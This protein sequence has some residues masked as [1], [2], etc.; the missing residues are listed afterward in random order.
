[1]KSDD[2]L[3]IS[4]GGAA[5]GIAREAARN[6][7]ESTG[8]PVRALILDTDDETLLSCPPSSGVS[9]SIFG[10]KRLSGSGTG[11]DHRLGAGALR[12]D[13]SMIQQQIGTPH[14]AI[15]L[16][17][18]GGGTSGAGSHLLTQ[19]RDQGVAT[20]TIATVPFSFEGDDRKRCAAV[21]LPT[22][23]SASDAI[24][25][26]PLDQLIPESYRD[27][28]ATEAFAYAAD[29]LAAGIGLFWTLL[30]RP[31]FLAFDATRF[32]QFITFGGS[33]GL[34]FYF[35]DATASGPDRARIILDQLLASPLFRADGIDR[36]AN[37]AN[38]VVGVL[39]GEDLRLCEL[40]T[41]MDGLRGYC[42]SLKE[43]F[44]G[45]ALAPNPDGALTVV[46]LAFSSPALDVS[47]RRDDPLQP[48]TIGK[49]ARA[50][51]RQ[52]SK[53]GTV[54]SRFTD[55]EQTVLNGENLDEPTYMR[56]GI[57]LIR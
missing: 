51:T 44:L 23:E 2:L 20:L 48:P 56:R 27:R 5:A 17:C 33:T 22:L 55:M 39:A 8:V 14:L 24:A 43:A 32:H 42:S 11:G 35:T 10:T 49:R 3:L 53:L 15:V 46:V 47:Q 52:L 13:Y 28:P 37:A 29:R 36:L 45:T 26:I 9:V 41:L 25:R 54:N 38:I 16:I 31:S 4:L 1:M 50:R 12:D 34:P 19:L 21:V 18:G 57:R 40:S 7:A 30:S 6:L